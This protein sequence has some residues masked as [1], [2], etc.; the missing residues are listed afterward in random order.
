MD[1]VVERIFVGSVF[2]IVLCVVRSWLR[3]LRE[4]QRLAL[5]DGIAM[6]ECAGRETALLLPLSH[7]A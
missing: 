6:Q 5:G 1:W 2:T 4:N 7:R 3:T